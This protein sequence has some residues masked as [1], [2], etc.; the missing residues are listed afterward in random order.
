MY[1]DAVKNDNIKKCYGLTTLFI[2]TA[3]YYI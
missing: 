3:E 1:D 2:D